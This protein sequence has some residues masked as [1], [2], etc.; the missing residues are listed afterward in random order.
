MD[1]IKDRAILLVRIAGPKRLSQAGDTNHERWKNISKGA[2]RM[3][4]EE[5][6]VL[7]DLYPQYALWLASGKIA[8][9][10]GQTSPEYDEANSKLVSQNAG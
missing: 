4:T 7:I 6:S 1:K 2:I 9:E 10:I 3:S 5:I 8:P